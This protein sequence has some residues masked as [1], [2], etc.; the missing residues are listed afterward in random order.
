MSFHCPLCWHVLSFILRS[1]LIYYYFAQ[2]SHTLL[3]VG[4]I[5]LLILAWRITPCA[6]NVGN[7]VFNE[8][9]SFDSISG[10]H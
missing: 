4:A 2:Y 10:I 1:Y 7:E 3:I 5:V 8:T 6:M 9:L